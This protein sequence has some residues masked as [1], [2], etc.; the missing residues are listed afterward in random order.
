MIDSGHLLELNQLLQE[1]TIWCDQLECLVKQRPEEDELIQN[2][3]QQ[4]RTSKS[5]QPLLGRQGSTPK[6]RT[7]YFMYASPLKWHQ[8]RISQ[9]NIPQELESVAKL[10]WTVSVATPLALV[11]TLQMRPLIL[12][13]TAHSGMLPPKFSRGTGESRRALLLEDAHGLGQDMDANEL[14]DLGSWEVGSH[15]EMSE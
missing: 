14:L 5:H 12:H 10:P 4:E 3:R 15:G 1:E 8:Q 13:I 11:E 6:Q 7:V 9:L 2:W